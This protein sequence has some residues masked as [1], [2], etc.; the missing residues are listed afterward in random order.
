MNSSDKKRIEQMLRERASDALQRAY[1]TLVHP[2]PKMEQQLRMRLDAA[3]TNMTPTKASIAR[4]EAAIEAANQA[5]F[6]IQWHR[7]RL[8]EYQYTA[9]PKTESHPDLVAYTKARNDMAE[10]TREARDLAIITLW[11][12]DEFDLQGFFSQIDRAA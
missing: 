5:G 1:N 8:G 4:M 12:S 3:M 2:T 6:S 9:A 11:S 7:P 10:A